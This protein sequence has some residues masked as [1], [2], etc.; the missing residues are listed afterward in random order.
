MNCPGEAL[1]RRRN[2]DGSFFGNI[3]IDEDCKLVMIC[4]DALYVVSHFEVRCYS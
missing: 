2:G 1:T 4:H 3:G